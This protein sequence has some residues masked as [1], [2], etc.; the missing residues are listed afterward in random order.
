MFESMYKTLGKMWVLS[1]SCRLV[2]IY[3]YNVQLFF[4]CIEFT[5]S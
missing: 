1:V 4:L 3:C 2:S 5:D